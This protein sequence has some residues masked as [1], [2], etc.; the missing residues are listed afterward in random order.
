MLLCRDPVK[1]MAHGFPPQHKTAARFISLTFQKMNQ[2]FPAQWK[3]W[4]FCMP[5]AHTHATSRTY[6]KVKPI[7]LGGTE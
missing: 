6:S 7:G 1:R 3:D 2:P 4:F 5:R